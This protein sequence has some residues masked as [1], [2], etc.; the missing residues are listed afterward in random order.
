VPG[1]AAVADATELS[2]PSKGYEFASRL[3][4]GDIALVDRL[5]GRLQVPIQDPE[6]DLSSVRSAR[7]LLTRSTAA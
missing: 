6:S 7:P 2:K 4:A 5:A 1:A 3:L